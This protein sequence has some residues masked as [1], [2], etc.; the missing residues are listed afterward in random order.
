[1]PP[2][3]T[4]TASTRPR[5]RP[6]KHGPAQEARLLSEAALIL[7]QNGA[8]SLALAELAERLGLS[9]NTLYHYCRDAQDLVFRC[10]VQSCEATQQ[11]IDAAA[12]LPTGAADRL[13]GFVLR[14]LG[15]DGPPLAALYDVDWLPDPGRAHIRRLEAEMVDGLADLIATGIGQG[16]FR[17]CDAR[18]AAR[19][20]LGVIAWVTTSESWLGDGGPESARPQ[21]AEAILDFFLDGLAPAS[22]ARPLPVAPDV[23]SLFVRSTRPLVSADLNAAKVEFLLA[24]ASRLFNRRGVDGV[25]I[26]DIAAVVGATKGTLYY[27]FSD[28][29]D[30]VARSYERA[31]DIFETIMSAG[32]DLGTDGLSRALLVIHLN[33]QAQAGPLS[34]LAPQPGLP[35]VHEPLRVRLRQRAAG[36]R[37]A[38]IHNLV[39]GIEDGSC[40]PH[41][42]AMIAEASAG[43]FLWLPRWYQPGDP[44]GPRDLADAVCDLAAFGLRRRNV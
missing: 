13:S 37:R 18:L 3:E 22:S 2:T 25:R 1:M 41:D 11:A 31:F 29:A 19:C 21:L 17:P 23:Q 12:C 30:I 44:L 9:R 4:Q 36:L 16:E 6:P 27:H 39:Q 35:R 15:A 32:I 7:N 24:E 10:F 42:A 43:L 28:K 14:R 34:P 20:L 33:L 38:A 8:S 5:G 40:R 26:D